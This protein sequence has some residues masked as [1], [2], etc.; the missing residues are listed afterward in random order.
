MDYVIKKAGDHKIRL[1]IPISNYWDEFGGI[2]LLAQWAGLAPEKK[3]FYDREDFYRDPR[4]RALY[5]DYV[6][7]ITSRVNSY[8]GVA[9]RDDPTIL[10][11]EPIN[12]ARGRSDTSGKTVASWLNW[13]AGVNKEYPIGS[14][15]GCIRRRESLRFATIYKPSFK[16]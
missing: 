8:T 11:W 15:R 5:Q 6:Q 16:W 1:I 2:S 10:M 12:E 14:K 4:A 13:A 9:Y 7:R 3:L